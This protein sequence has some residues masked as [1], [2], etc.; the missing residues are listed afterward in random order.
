MAAQGGLVTYVSSDTAGIVTVREEGV[1]LFDDLPL[2]RHKC[3]FS[4]LMTGSAIFFLLPEMIQQL[5]RQI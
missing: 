4:L 3:T 2:S 5:S 1:S